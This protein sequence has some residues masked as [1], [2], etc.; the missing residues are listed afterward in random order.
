ML[1]HLISKL[2]PASYYRP[3]ASNLVV[4]HVFTFVETNYSNHKTSTIL[5][6][7]NRRGQFSATHT[8]QALLHTISV[9]VLILKIDE[10]V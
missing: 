1:G 10:F 7:N 5:F 3:P 9:L 2:S 6:W 4:T 8:S